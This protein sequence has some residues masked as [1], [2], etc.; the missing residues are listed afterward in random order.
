MQLGEPSPREERDLPLF[1]REHHEGVVTVAGQV[2]KV[3]DTNYLG[4]SLTLR[5]LIKSDVAETAA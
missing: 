3:L 4:D 2:I 1:W 5:E